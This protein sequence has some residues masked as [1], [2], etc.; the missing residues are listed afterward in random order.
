[1]G[2][3]VGHSYTKATKGKERSKLE[4][5]S[6]SRTE[7]SSCFQPKRRAAVNSE[8]SA[9]VSQVSYYKVLERS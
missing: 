7:I 6:G 1:M 4:A 8:L 9:S 5:L 3:A 2:G